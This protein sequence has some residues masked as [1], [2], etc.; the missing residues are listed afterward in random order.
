MQWKAT[1]SKGVDGVKG[2]RSDPGEIDGSL[3]FTLPQRSELQDSRQ[4]KV[5]K[6]PSGIILIVYIRQF[7]FFSFTDVR[8]LQCFSDECKDCESQGL[9][10]L[11]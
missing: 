8:Y 2:E 1:N 11:K 6:N 9:L 5:Q 3:I 4:F 7:L 10:D